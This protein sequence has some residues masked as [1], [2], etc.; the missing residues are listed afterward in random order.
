LD[1]AAAVATGR[2]HL[3]QARCAQARKLFQHLWRTKGRSGS[4]AEGRNGCGLLEHFGF[5]NGSVLLRP[6]CCSSQTEVERRNTAA[7]ARPLSTERTQKKRRPHRP[8]VPRSAAVKGSAT[9]L[10]RIM[11]SSALRHTGRLPHRSRPHC[12]LPLPLLL[13]ELLL[14]PC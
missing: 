12:S 10:P 1:D 11:Q 2:D 3:K 9:P 13:L 7:R 5:T 6:C 14:L 8:C 4:T